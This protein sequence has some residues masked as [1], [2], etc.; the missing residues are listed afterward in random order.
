[1]RLAVFVI[2]AMVSSS[3]MFADEPSVDSDTKA[4]SPDE[5]VAEFN[6]MGR[7][8]AIPDPTFRFPDADTPIERTTLKIGQ[9][10]PEITGTTLEGEAFTLQFTAETPATL[11]VFWSS[12]CGACLHEAP[13]ERAL[14]EL[15]K[16]RGFRLISVNC[17]ARRGL[18]KRTAKQHEIDCLTLHDGD[19]G[20]ISEALGV[21]S[22]PTLLLLDDGG[23]IIASTSVLRSQR[24]SAASPEDVV[25]YERG[26]C[27]A[28]RQ[29]FPVDDKAAKS[30]RTKP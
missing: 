9:Q 3:T 6:A 15:Y 1:M 5:V 25:V 24:V 22:F 17:D 20:P 30:G 2:A 21:G 18:A 4:K 16:D 14:H 26:L 7:I 13:F 23:K 27:G 10:L 29:L 19:D 8:A 11:L 28:L 12:S